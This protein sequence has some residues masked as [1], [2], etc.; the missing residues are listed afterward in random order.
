MNNTLTNPIIGLL[1]IVFCCV[2]CTTDNRIFKKHQKYADEFEL[3][4]SQQYFSNKEPG[5]QYSVNEVINLN[6]S[7]F[8]TLKN[9]GIFSEKS[10]FFYSNKDCILLITR[11]SGNSIGGFKDILVGMNNNVGEF[12][13]GINQ[14]YSLNQNENTPSL[15][16]H[17]YNIT[18]SLNMTIVKN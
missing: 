9:E 5:K 13:C 14:I 6:D 15:S 10:Y 18:G 17:S 3:I 8:I 1:L 12:L 4:L 2:S 16:L 7:I 11:I